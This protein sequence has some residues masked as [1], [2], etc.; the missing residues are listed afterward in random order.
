M[1]LLCYSPR[2]IGG[3][4]LEVEGVSSV[5]ASYGALQMTFPVG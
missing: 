5:T 4:R 3:Y 1:K 2:Y